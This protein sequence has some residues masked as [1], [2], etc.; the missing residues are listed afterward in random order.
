MKKY[1]GFVLCFGVTP[2]NQLYLTRNLFDQKTKAEYLKMVDDGG[3]DSID[4]TQ[5]GT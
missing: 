4:L 3:E 2:L 1:T 5:I